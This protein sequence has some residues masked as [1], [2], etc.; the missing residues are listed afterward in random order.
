VLISAFN[1]IDSLAGTL[2]LF[3]ASPQEIQW[4]AWKISSVGL[5]VWF[6]KVTGG[7]VSWSHIPP[8]RR[9]S[10]GNAHAR[11]HRCCLP[12]L[13]AR[14]FPPVSS[15]EEDQGYAFLQ[16]QLPDA[17]SLQRTDAVMRKIECP[18]GAHARD[19]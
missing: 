19:R 4:P 2:A 7:Y 11:R 13:W 18:A 10:H 1:A 8:I 17:A 5:T 15:P 16:I 14:A 3:A 12:G 9:W 6:D